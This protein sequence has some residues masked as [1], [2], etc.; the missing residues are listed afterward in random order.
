DADGDVVAKSVIVTQTANPG[1]QKI[2][3]GSGG[4][5]DYRGFTVPGTLAQSLLYELPDGEPTANDVFL[6][7]AAGGEESALSYGTFHTDNFSVAGG[8]ITIK[9]LGVAIA[10]INASGS[11]GAGNFLRGDGSWQ[12]VS[13]SADTG[14][15]EGAVQFNASGALE[16]DANIVW[17]NTTKTLIFIVNGAN[18]A[19]EIGDGTHN[20][21]AGTHF[22]VEGA[23]EFDGELDA[24]GGVDVPTSAGYQVGNAQIDFD[25]MAGSAVPPL[26]AD[27]IDTLTE[28]AAA[29]KSS[30]DAT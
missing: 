21:S 6:I 11:P 29:L 5:T 19:I 4:G 3:E 14:G 18:E 8:D 26:P 13:A 28:I 30:D 22:Y 10:E 23:V 12:A 2:L 27:S 1:E 16:S 24:G 17:N 25:D 9:D 20:P 15:G 7:A